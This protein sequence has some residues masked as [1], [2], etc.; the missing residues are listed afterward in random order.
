MIVTV[1][2]NGTEKTAVSGR[3]SVM[4]TVF[5]CSIAAVKNSSRSGLHLPYGIALVSRKEHAFRTVFLLAKDNS[6]AEVSIYPDSS[7]FDAWHHHF[8]SWKITI[9]GHVEDDIYIRDEG[10]VPHA[11]T[12]DFR[13]WRITDRSGKLF[14][15][16]KHV[17]DEELDPHGLYS[18]LQLRFLIQKRFIAFCCSSGCY[19]A[20]EEANGSSFALQRHPFHSVIWQSRIRPQRPSWTYDFSSALMPSDQGRPREGMIFFLLPSLLMAAAALAAA[21]LSLRGRSHDPS[22][23]VS[24]LLMPGVMLFSAGFLLPMRYWAESFYERK[25]RKKAIET[26]EESLCAEVKR[27]EKQMK[28]RIKEA[29]NRFPDPGILEKNASEGVLA[30]FDLYDADFLSLRLGRSM[31]CFSVTDQTQPTKN[32]I[33]AEQ[34]HK[35]LQ[36]MREPVSGPLIIDLTEERRMALICSDGRFFLTVIMQLVLLHSPADLGIVIIADGQMPPWIQRIPHAVRIE[37]ASGCMEAVASISRRHVCICTDVRTLQYLPKEEIVILFSR[38]PA[39]DPS[40]RTVCRAEGRNGQLYRRSHQETHSFVPDYYTADPDIMFSSLASGH[41]FPLVRQVPGFLAAHGVRNAEEL[42]AAE[43]WKEHA[44]RKDLTACCGTDPDGNPVMLNLQDSSSGP[45]G[46]LAGTTGSGKS[47]FLLS[48]IL[49]LAVRYSPRDFSLVL[50]DFKGGG[51]LQSLSLHG[52]K[53]PHLASALTNLDDYEMERALASLRIA[54]RQREQLFRRMS[55]LTGKAVSDI[56]TC[57]SLWRKEYG[58]PYPGHLLIAVD[59]FAE[60]KKEHPAFLDE[61]VTIARVGRSL[62]IHLL[63]ATQS[64]SGI[65]SGQIRANTGFTVCLRVQN[66]A[67]STEVLG[68]S[69]AAAS[70]PAGTFWLKTADGIIQGAAAYTGKAAVPKEHIRLFSDRGRCLFHTAEGGGISEREAVIRELLAASEKTECRAAP[71]WTA[72]NFRMKVSDALQHQIIGILDDYEKGRWTALK[73]TPLFAVWSTDRSRAERFLHTVMMDI[74]QE[75]DET[76]E[77]YLLTDKAQSPYEACLGF[78]GLVQYED[79]ARIDRLSKRL[80]ERGSRRYLIIDD[81]AAFLKEREIHGEYLHQWIRRHASLHLEIVLFAGI[82]G[83][84][85]MRDLSFMTGRA[86]LSCSGVQ[87]A[88]AVFEQ[89]VCW[90]LISGGNAAASSGGRVLRMI[91]PEISIDEIASFCSAHAGKGGYHLW[92]MPDVIRCRDYPG[93]IIL[94]ISC[95]SGKPVEADVSEQL[96]TVFADKEAERKCLQYYRACGLQVHK[97]EKATPRMGMAAASFKDLNGISPANV[98]YAGPCPAAL[99]PYELREYEDLKDGDGL[100]VRNAVKERIRLCHEK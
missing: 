86:V 25:R 8:G 10:L 87:E 81:T 98:L 23:A 76:C 35:A 18:L 31:L 69:L 100:L 27:A 7:G 2:E 67:E 53:I 16:G 54:C 75:A 26:Y 15:S 21:I 17:Q 6:K 66:R 71:L 65:V 90:N 29:E 14:C 48:M 61:L 11:V 39:E 5:G 41:I 4:T 88:S 72:G 77:V 85:R 93:K 57:Q 92:K 70:V 84:I 58:L 74:L 68:S 80:G 43:S 91:Y 1:H 79:H 37:D 19:S 62:G 3:N 33:C 28:E 59:E 30:S 49:S 46:L 78:A 56:G 32:G 45:H 82:A 42:A 22:A 38:G 94:G 97:Y 64:P 44:E 50:F 12:I 73:R 9:G 40:I 96:V 63:L 95:Q 20:L 24:S 47:E 52:K 55:A 89:P 34:Y 83:D 51:L 99:L 13:A 60:M 36:Q